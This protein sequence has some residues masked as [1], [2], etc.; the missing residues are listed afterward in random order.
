MSAN[1]G[2]SRWLWVVALGLL[3]LG[4]M[5]VAGAVAGY[6]LWWKPRQEQVALAP[7]PEPAPEPTAAPVPE[8]SQTEPVT[9][10]AEPVVSAEP[11]PVEP[12]PDAAAQRSTPRTAPSKRPPAT[13]RPSAAP[14]RAAAPGSP[15][16]GKLSLEVDAVQDHLAPDTVDVMKFEIRVGNEVVGSVDVRFGARGVARQNGK[17]QADL[18]K[19]PTGA[20]ELTLAGGPAGGGVLRGSIKVHLEDGARLKLMA[21]VRYMSPTDRE[22]RFR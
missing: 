14:E 1:Q 19:L 16:N 13:A 6:F 18:S 22:L 17:G 7:T 20:H 10:E 15:R 8:P 11:K 2:S 12:A 9:T 21:R 4:A 3:G 5:T